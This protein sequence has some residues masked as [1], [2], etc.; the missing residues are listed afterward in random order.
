MHLLV[1]DLCCHL[2]S[3]SLQDKKNQPFKVSYISFPYLR[4]EFD[5]RM[6]MES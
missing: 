6:F 1:K 5:M 2:D 4:N 3:G